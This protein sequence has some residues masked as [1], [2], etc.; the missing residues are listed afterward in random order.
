VSSLATQARGLN[1]AEQQRAAAERDRANRQAQLRVLEE[2]R[3]AEQ[4]ASAASAADQRKKIAAA[5]QQLELQAQLQAQRAAT[6]QQTIPGS[7]Y[8]WPIAMS[9]DPRS[10]VSMTRAAIV[11][12]E[13]SNPF[14]TVLLDPKDG[15]GK[16]YTF[17]LQPPNFMIRNGMPRAS[18]RVGDEV[19][20]TGML[21]LGGGP[22]VAE[23]STP[24]RFHVSGQAGALTFPDGTIAALAST[25]LSSD[26]RKLFERSTRNPSNSCDA[27]APPQSCIKIEGAQA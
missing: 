26:G 16:R 27:T 24:A 25:I 2:E 14:V 1:T 12:I 18:F 22:P 23:G 4:Q 8:L 15:T 19:T 20:I 13:W 7:V 6:A 9:F 21:A 5:L 3:A 11:K 10:T 17:L